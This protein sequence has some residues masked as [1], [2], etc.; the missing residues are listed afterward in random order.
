M[1]TSLLSGKVI[2]CAVIVFVA[3]GCA[4]IIKG[5]SQ[6][7]SIK[8][9]PAEARVVVS[10]LN[11]GRDIH[12]GSTPV[13][14]SLKR[15]AGWFKSGKYKVT[16]EKAGFKKEEVFLEGTPGGWYIAGNF[17]FGGLIGWLAVDPA[18]GA[19]WTL[20]P[21][22]I[23]AALKKEGASRQH[24][25]RIVVVLRES[26]PAELEGKLKLLRPPSQD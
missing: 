16:I 25:D 5:S 15:G 3:S 13:T 8:S 22:D 18:T 17:F 19:M 21:E 14:L 4:T 26:V 9:N 7:V 6:N 10:D 24:G 11:S 20:E 23:D 2:G 1:R 12:T